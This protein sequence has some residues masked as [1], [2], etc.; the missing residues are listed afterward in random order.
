MTSSEGSHL[1]A[2]KVDD[3]NTVMET[4]RPPNGVDYTEQPGHF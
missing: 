4:P 3:A 2:E 1:T